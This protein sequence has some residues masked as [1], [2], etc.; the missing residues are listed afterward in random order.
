LTGANNSTEC[1]RPPIEW[2]YFNDIALMKDIHKKFGHIKLKTFPMCSMFRYRLYYKYF[3]GMKRIA[4]LDL[5]CYDKEKAENELREKFGWEKYKN[6]HYENV[7]TRF[8]EG[9]YLPKKFG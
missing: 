6:K 3:K 7:F 1:V 2:V 4:L 8:Y 9:Y 5:I